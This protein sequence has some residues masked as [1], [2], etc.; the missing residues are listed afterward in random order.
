MTNL[1]ATIA[2]IG[3]PGYNIG[4]V[5]KALIDGG[6]DP[7]EI[8]TAGNKAIDV[9]ALTVL[10]IMLAVH[11]ISEGDYTIVYAIEAR[12]KAIE[13]ALGIGS[14]LVRNASFYW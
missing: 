4:S 5:N 14:N 10:N 8:Y 13:K 1:E 7:D 2:A 12:I 11:E 9:A 6:L 3:I